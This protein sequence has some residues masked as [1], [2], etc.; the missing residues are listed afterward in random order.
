MN[1]LAVRLK[2]ESDAG[3]PRATVQASR[4]NGLAREVRLAQAPFVV[5]VLTKIHQRLRWSQAQP[6]WF[7][8]DRRE[9]PRPVIQAFLSISG[10]PDPR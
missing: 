2:P 8:A 5:R 10:L 7:R 9:N 3:I 6:R 4:A 1:R